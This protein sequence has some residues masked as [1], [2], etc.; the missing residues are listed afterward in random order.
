MLIGIGAMAMTASAAGK[1]EQ[2]ATTWYVSASGNDGWSGTRPEGD[3]KGADG[4]FATLQ[5]A[6]DALAAYNKAR[7]G[8]AGARPDAR[9]ILRGGVYTINKS[10]QL[11]AA[12]C[13]TPAQPV[14]IQAQEGERVSLVG[15]RQIPASAFVPVTD[16]AVLSRLDEQARKNVLQADLKALGLSDYG[17]MKSRG[18]DRP[19][20][21]AGLELF[22]D[23]RPMPLARWPNEGW[24]KI[25]GFGEPMSNEWGE[26]VGK[27]DGGFT[28]E[29]DRPRGWKDTGELWVHGYWCWDWANSYEKVASIDLEKRL[30]RTASPHGLYAFR[31]GQRFYFLNVL[32]ELDA[33][34]EWFVDRQTGV[35][36]FWP[37]ARLD[38]A[39]I[40]VSTLESPVFDLKAAS[41]VTIRGLTIE[42]TRG[43]AVSIEGGQGARVEDCTIRNIGTYAVM[44]QGGG[45]QGLVG[46]HIYNTG[47]GGVNLSG[48]DR[49]TLESSGQFVSNC[50]IHDIGRWSKCYVPAVLVAGVGARVDHNL[51]HDHPH[52][53]ILFS[54]NEHAIEFNEIHH[55]ALET[56]DVG[57]I[58]TGR[59][60]TY[61]GNVIRYNYIHHTGGVGMGSMGVYM[62]DCVSGTRIYGNVFHKVQRAVM[63][64]GGRDFTV[65]NNVFV[66]CMPAVQMDGRGIDKNPVWHDMVYKIMK[67]RLEEVNWK[68][69]PYATRYPQILDLEKYYAK[70]DG[71]PPENDVLARNICVGGKWLDNGWNCPKDQPRQVDNLVGQDPQ[72][73]DAAG[74]N[75]QLKDGSP[76]WKLGFQK[77]P[78]EALGLDRAK[79][80]LEN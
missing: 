23:D 56:G 80:K 16:Q 22:V 18:F 37:P 55:V 17:Q 20:T 9:I 39:R 43:L 72:F 40:I 13:G 24:V 42:C 34:G 14:V 53:A 19:T 67:P 64:G 30:I 45:G 47:D 26:K 15:G 65:E 59:D 74:G 68:Q 78:I 50:H 36:Y 63:L 57:A 12:H 69:P 49:K 60:W 6:C 79:Y 70:D 5:R 38:K 44:I 76:A 27:L 11:T 51:I 54:G 58:Y 75:F 21:P 10:V 46:C 4:P 73:I 7:P 29:G 41:Y 25:A 35:L 33:P 1:A 28:Y 31:P 61:R 66:D 48:G 52:C 62:D 3:A 8:S 2:P 77:I 32:E 71:V